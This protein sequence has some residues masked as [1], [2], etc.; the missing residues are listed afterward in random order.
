MEKM[1]CQKTLVSQ[2]HC[3]IVRRFCYSCTVFL[4][5][6]FLDQRP[7]LPCVENLH[8]KEKLHKVK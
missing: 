4:L 5:V 2:R 6:M 3:K 8:T 7:D 1:F